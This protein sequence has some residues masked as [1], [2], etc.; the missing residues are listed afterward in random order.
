MDNVKKPATKISAKYGSDVIVDMIRAIGIEYVSLNPGATFRGLHDS[1]VNY[2]GNT[3]PELILCNHENIAVS[4]ATGYAIAS[5][6]PM[7]AIVHNVVGLL[8]ATNAIYNS[9]L[10][11]VPMLVFGATGPMAVELRRPWIDWIHTALVQGNVVRDYVKWDDQPA[12]VPSAIDSILR[13]YMLSMTDPIGPVYICLDAEIQ[14]SPLNQPIKIPDVSQFAPP[15]PVYPDP[16]ALDETARLLVEAK[17][18]V[19]LVDL[20]EQSGSMEALVSLAEMLSI[21]VIDGGQMVNFPSANPLNL[22]GLSKEVL[23][24]ADVVLA[25][26]VKD[27]FYSLTTV[28]RNTRLA[29]LIIPESAKVIEISMRHFAWR[30]WSQEYGRLQATDLHISGDA[31]LALPELVSRCKQLLTR[32]KSKATQIKARRKL[33]EAKHIQM[34]KKWQ[35]EAQKAWKQSPVSLPRLAGELWQ[36]VKNDDWVLVN[37]SL[38]DWV[39]KTWEFTRPYQFVR[40]EGLGCGIGVALGAALAHKGKGKLVVDIQP[41]GDMLF[42]SSALWTAAHYKI[43][44]LVVMFNNRSYYNDEVHQEVVAK[45]RGR[46]VENKTIGLRI[47]EPAVDF[48]RL[49]SAYGVYSEGPV[50]NPDKLGDVLN[51]AAKYVKDTGQCALVDVVSQ[52]R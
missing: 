18:P 4:L 21:P 11:H 52:F 37:G 30:S 7:A 10:T 42:A 8:N 46:P 35:E 9:W 12:S 38:N 45:T 20:L 3:K 24:E 1:L 39:W 40:R 17:K 26:N 51:R 22:S 41:D 23:A 49:A 31:S 33:L 50:E 13:G 29:R 44:L 5:G 36:T 43:P 28:D 2:G 48:A 25:L 32:N 34:H 6:R 27:L 16:Q 15:T 14:D 19:V 47:E